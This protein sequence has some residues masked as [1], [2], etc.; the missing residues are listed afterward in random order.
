MVNGKVVDESSEVEQIEETEKWKEEMK[1]KRNKNKKKVTEKDS[2]AEQTFEIGIFVALLGFCVVRINDCG[3]FR[4][5]F[6]C[7][8]DACGSVAMCT[9]CT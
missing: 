7:V 4:Y 6:V 9:C 5:V 8:K 1:I 2:E 3:Q